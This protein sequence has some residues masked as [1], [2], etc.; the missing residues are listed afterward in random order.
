MIRL[1]IVLVGV[2]LG[3]PVLAAAQAPAPI[4]AAMPPAAKPAWTKG[5][6]PISRE[7]YWN[8]IEQAI[9]QPPAGRV[10]VDKNPSAMPNVP[11]PSAWSTSSDVAPESATS[12]S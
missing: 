10:V 11:G 4:K 8:G 5:I 9:E 3:V 2:V 1:R 12:K 7:S 6:Q